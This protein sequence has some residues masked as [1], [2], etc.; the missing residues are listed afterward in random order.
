MMGR[1]RRYGRRANMKARVGIT[2][3]AVIGGGAIAIAAVASSHGSSPTA[4]A[5]GYS[6][7]ASHTSTTS[8]WNQLNSAMNGW[9]RSTSSSMSTLAS[10]TSQRTFSQTSKHGKTL[11]EQRGIVVL[12]TKKFIILQSSNGS[13]HLWVLSGKTKVQNVSSNT[14]GTA[15]MTANTSATKQ[16]M[17]SS[18]MIPATTLMAGSPLVASRMLT[19]SPAPQTITVQVSGTDLTVTVTIA[20]TTATVSQ[21]A[22]MP[23][24]GNPTWSPSTTTVNPFMGAATM[25]MLARGDLATIVG[26][27]S[28]NLLHAQI[29][30]FTPLSTSD[31]GGAASNGVPQQAASPVATSTVG[32]TGTH[33]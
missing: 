9:A 32:A 4:Q 1:D 31:V 33:Y 19:P 17:Q 18:N 20:Q 10:M 7:R 15:A 26:T 11:A 12:A 2:A 6:A 14:A 28:H 3:A 16:A 25:P 27:R 22:T 23:A 5:A 29:V 21:T 8:E 13:L 30:L 24:S